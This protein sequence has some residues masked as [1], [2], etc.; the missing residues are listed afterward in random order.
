MRHND[1]WDIP[2]GVLSVPKS[3]LLECRLNP[4]PESTDEIRV[5][6]TVRG[7][8]AEKLREAARL[9]RRDAKWVMQQLAEWAMPHLVLPDEGEYADLDE[10][11]HKLQA[12]REAIGASTKRRWARQ[13]EMNGIEDGE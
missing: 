9:Y 2:N 4:R 11:W 10:E 8:N 1:R 7:G 12:A 3:T 6:V 13:K 5:V